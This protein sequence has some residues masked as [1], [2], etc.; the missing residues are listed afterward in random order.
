[1]M[2]L[3]RFVF[4]ASFCVASVSKTAESPDA[5]P[6]LFPRTTYRRKGCLNLGLSKE[7][8]EVQYFDPPPRQATPSHWHNG[9]RSASITPLIVP[10]HSQPTIQP[11]SCYPFDMP[12]V[13]LSLK[14]V[15]TLLSSLFTAQTV[16]KSFFKMFRDRESERITERTLVETFGGRN[17]TTW[18]SLYCAEANFNVTCMLIWLSCSIWSGFRARGC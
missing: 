1:M 16:L 18:L 7:P 11:L 3:A 12:T 6:V 9:S 14:Y 10:Y 13:Y 17:K 5:Q 8:C 4:L 2:S 15:F